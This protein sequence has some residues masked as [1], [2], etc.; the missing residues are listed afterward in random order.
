MNARA[1]LALA[2]ALLL[3][4]S[5]TACS[6]STADA[7]AAACEAAD[8]LEQAVSD[9][10]SSFGPTMTVDDL[11]DSR[12][13]VQDAYDE[14]DRALDDVAE[15]RSDD[16][17]QAYTDFDDAVSDIDGAQSLVQALGSLQ[18]DLGTLAQA[19][20]DAVAELDCG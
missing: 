8:D 4:A 17:D 3:G 19:R 11:R 1:T 6:D 15:D 10:Q 9:A 12:E 16:L 5:L 2:S 13:E 14:L 18:D 20:S 7:E